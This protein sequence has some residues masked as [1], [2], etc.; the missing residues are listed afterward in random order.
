MKK[1]VTKKASTTQQV[2]HPLAYCLLKN[3]QEGSIERDTS[4]RERANQVLDH[5]DETI[6]IFA[7]E[8]G[9]KHYDQEGI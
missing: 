8:D 3:M 4:V 5:F 9:Q 2:L 6:F 7:D 1:V